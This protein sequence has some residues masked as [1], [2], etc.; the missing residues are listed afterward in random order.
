VRLPGDVVVVHPG[1][2]SGSRRWPV[3]RWQSVVRELVGLG[4]RVV[5]TG[6][7]DER[8]LCALVADAAPGAENWCGR[9]DLRGLAEQV[10]SARLLLCGDTGVAHLATAVATPSVLL[11]GPTDPAQ[12]GPALD[13]QLHQVIW[14]AHDGDAAGDPHGAEVDVRL[15]RTGV[16]EVLLAAQRM[17][18]SRPTEDGAPNTGRGRNADVPAH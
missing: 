12:W 10:A 18:E 4:H 3:S 1:A 7:P 2:A 14:H 13:L 16:D 6:V 11:F 5:V 9:L 8:E 17:L 15:A